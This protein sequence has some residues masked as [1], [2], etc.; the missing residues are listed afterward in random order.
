MTVVMALQVEMKVCFCFQDCD[1]EGELKW[2][3]IF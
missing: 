1:H 3:K 2:L